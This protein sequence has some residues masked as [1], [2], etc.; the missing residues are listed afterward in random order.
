MIPEVVLTI[1]PP[2]QCHK[3]I[4]HTAK[5]NLFT[6]RSGGEQKDTATIVDSAQDLSIHQE[7]IDKT[8]EEYQDALDA[9]TGVPP[10]YP[11]KKVYNITLHTLHVAYSQ[12]ESSHTQVDHAARLVEQIQPFQQ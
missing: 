6:I 2:K 5:F 1:V 12:K 10:H 3:A 7:Q 9:P 8:V 11:V 4:S